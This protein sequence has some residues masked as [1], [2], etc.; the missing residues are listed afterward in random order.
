MSFISTHF[1]A[2]LLMLAPMAIVT[3][4]VFLY[5]RYRRLNGGRN[6]LTKALLNP[7]GASLRGKL[8]EEQN[9]LSALLLVSA[10]LGAYIAGFAAGHELEMG[11]GT[12]FWTL[13]VLSYTITLSW[14][15]YRSIRSFKRIQLLRLGL[16]GEMATGEELSHLMRLGY[17]VFH[18][19]PG[20]NYNIDHAVIGP[21]GVFAVETKSHAKPQSGY[22]AKF[23]GRVIHYP[24]R[25]DFHA[26]EQAKR[27]AHSLGQ[28]LSKAI[29]RQIRVGAIVILP[30]WCV[31]QT[32]KSQGCQVIAS[33]QVDWIPKIKGASLSPEDITCIAHQLERL[34][35]RE[36]PVVLSE[37]DVG[38]Y[39]P[40][41][42]I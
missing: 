7:P 34:C 4:S 10:A 41:L 30:G 29:G 42:A 13:V 25:S 17:Y 12:T 37:S 32:G 14:L 5:R 22:E 18:D 6:P 15:I 11:T 31:T 38:K 27:N 39:E 35:R 33:G 36:M 19:I 40:K 2:P 16:D 24:D 8:I 26:V 23:D 1:G 28:F 9:E 3:A 20:A 21:N